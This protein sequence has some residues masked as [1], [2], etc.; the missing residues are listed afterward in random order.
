MIGMK[1]SRLLLFSIFALGSI[2]LV[3]E[4]SVLN[5]NVKDV[6]NRLQDLALYPNLAKKRLYGAVGKTGAIRFDLKSGENSPQSLGIGIATDGTLK[7]FLLTVYSGNGQVENPIILRKE[8]VTGES[9]WVFELL[10]PPE[11]VTVEI[12][13][14]ASTQT[15]SVV[16]IVHGYYFGY[17]VD[18]ENQTKPQ[19]Q[20][21]VRQNTLDSEKLSPN[22]LQNRVEFIR[23]PITK[24]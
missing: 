12:Q 2:A 16:E 3:A 23:A 11:E 21:P 20:N 6:T 4:P 7:E 9:Q 19:Q 14:L 5:Q 1:T 15:V 24:D 10:A 17:S 13:N 8:K 22:D 18:K